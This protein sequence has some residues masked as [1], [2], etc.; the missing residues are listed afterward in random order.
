MD[1]VARYTILKLLGN[2]SYVILESVLVI[3]KYESVT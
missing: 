1:V 2:Y 3:F